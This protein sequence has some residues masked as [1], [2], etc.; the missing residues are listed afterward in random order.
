ML[1][2]LTA[3]AAR[4]APMVRRTPLQLSRAL[5]ARYGAPVYLKREDLQAVR[6]YKIRGAFNLMAQLSAAEGAR[7]V[8]CASAGNHAQGFA[9]AALALGLR[10]TVFMPRVTPA[11]KVAATRFW[12]EAA[13]EV[14]LVGDTF[15][16]AAA[17]CAAHV[18]ASGATLK[19]STCAPA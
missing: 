13:V 6:S 9:A 12:G 16:E 8:A 1:V 2:L 10:G 4:I 17:A 3:A 18:A 15:D 11:Q 5:S 7:G 14:R 19:A